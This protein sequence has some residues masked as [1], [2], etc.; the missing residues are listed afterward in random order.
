MNRLETRSTNNNKYIWYCIPCI[1]CFK[2]ICCIVTTSQETINV[3]IVNDK[4]FEQTE[5]KII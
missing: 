2:F 1:Y 3:E 4:S 5:E